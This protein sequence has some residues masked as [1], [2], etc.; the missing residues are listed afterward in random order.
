MANNITKANYYYRFV[1]VRKA[2]LDSIPSDV[3]EHAIIPVLMDLMHL[4]SEQKSSS[5]LKKVLG[6]LAHVE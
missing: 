4:E 3:V 1:Q 6:V 5:L 2:C